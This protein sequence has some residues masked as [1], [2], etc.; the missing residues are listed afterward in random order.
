M[1]D[2]S[3]LLSNSN[4]KKQKKSEIEGEISCE[5]KRFIQKSSQKNF[6]DS[7]TFFRYNSLGDLTVRNGEAGGL[8]NPTFFKLR[9]ILGFE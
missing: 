7:I 5:I 6:L 2:I 8:K 4:V 9:G 1:Q 3:A